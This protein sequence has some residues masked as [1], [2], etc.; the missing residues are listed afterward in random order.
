MCQCGRKTT[1]KAQF[2]SMFKL[3][4]CADHKKS[5]DWKTTAANPMHMHM[6]TYTLQKHYGHNVIIFNTLV[7]Q[8]MLFP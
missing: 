8:D 5:T 7:I 6:Q 3:H 4:T 2:G 1:L